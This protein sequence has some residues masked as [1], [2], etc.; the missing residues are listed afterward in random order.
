[1]GF[2]ERSNFEVITHK[3]PSHRRRHA[4]SSGI[5]ATGHADGSISIFDPRAS[6]ALA[7][8]LSAPSTVHQ[9]CAVVGVRVAPD[10][11]SML[12][13]AESGTLCLTAF[14]TMRKLHTLDGLGP[15]AGPSP[16]A[17]S[18]DGAYVLARS[19]DSI[20]CW[21]ASDGEKVCSSEAAQAVCVCWDLPQ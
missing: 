7:A 14:D 15:V 13:Q 21:R 2:G 17:F 16:P 9:G 6:D 19:T 4:S 10:A 11:R 18:P 20:C 1:M 12:S 3:L 8:S 5:I